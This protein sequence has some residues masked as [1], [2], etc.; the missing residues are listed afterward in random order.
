MTKSWLAVWLSCV[1]GV[2]TLTSPSD[3]GRAMAKLL[4]SALEDVAHRSL[5][6]GTQSQN[7]VLRG[8]GQHKR[9]SEIDHRKTWFAAQ[10]QFDVAS[11]RSESELEAEVKAGLTK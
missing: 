8:S 10:R 5:G 4:E 11:S 6:S 7:F 9:S 1:Q 3:E 2:L